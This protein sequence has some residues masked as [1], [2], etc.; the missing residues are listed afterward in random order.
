MTT[1]SRPLPIVTTR[2][3]DVRIDVFLNID[4]DDP[5]HEGDEV[6]L[7][8]DGLDQPIRLRCSVASVQ[9]NGA[10]PLIG[11]RPCVLRA[12]VQRTAGRQELVS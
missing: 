12:K 10:W 11:P 5:L 2:L 8:L 3:D 1:L 9:Q 6:V 4:P 7:E